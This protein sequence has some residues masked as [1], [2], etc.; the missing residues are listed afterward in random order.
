MILVKLIKLMFAGF[1]K[2]DPLPVPEL[3]V[4][5][6]VPQQY[7]LLGLRSGATRK[8]NAVSDLALISF[9]YLL[10]VDEYTQKLRKKNTRII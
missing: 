3:V 1:M 9:F 10:R 5:V 6:A 7:D 2:I 4:P 8:K